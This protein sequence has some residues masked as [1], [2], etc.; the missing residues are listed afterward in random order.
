M[1]FLKPPCKFYL[2]TCF[3]PEAVFMTGLS[4]VLGATFA[5][6]GYLSSTLLECRAV[7]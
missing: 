1:I 5:R 4:Q 2:D 6:S 3:V 7:A